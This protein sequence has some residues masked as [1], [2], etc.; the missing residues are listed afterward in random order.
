MSV[1][2]DSRGEGPVRAGEAGLPAVS[3]AGLLDGFRASAPS[4]VAFAYEWWRYNAPL[5]DRI[6]QVVSPAARVVEIGCG[7]GALTI[8]LSAYGYA[9]S[10]VDRDPAVVAAAHTLARQFGVTCDFQVGDAFAM[11]AGPVLADLAFSA[12]VL[13]HFSSEDAIRFLQVQ[14][15]LARRVLA[16]VPTR[17]AL[18]NDPSTEVSRARPLGL[19]QLRHLFRRAGLQVVRQFGYGT[20]D[21]LFS[22]IYRYCVPGAGQWLLQNHLAYACSIGCIGVKG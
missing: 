12:G 15:R 6:R 18:R 5:V 8:L 7:T 16:V 14:G 4:P 17:F 3:W 22:V 20:P 11:P 21:G 19:I 10:G 1:T 2:D 9:A 13:E